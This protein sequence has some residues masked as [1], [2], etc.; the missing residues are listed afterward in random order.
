MRET[1]QCLQ[2]YSPLLPQAGSP[3]LA[4]SYH[5]AMAAL[6]SVQGQ[7]RVTSEPQNVRQRQTK[8]LIV[9][10]WYPSVVCG[11]CDLWFS[12]G[13]P[14]CVDFEGCP[15]NL[16]GSEITQWWGLQVSGA[17]QGSLTLTS[18][19][20]VII[21]I[22]INNTTEHTWLIKAHLPSSQLWLRWLRFG[23]TR[24]CLCC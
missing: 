17:S 3:H 5:R 19:I 1:L 4:G 2:Y 20:D 24:V 12:A 21:K 9:A 16:P 11:N 14:L 7:T 8:S 10:R 6:S 23:W 13:S 15:E 22:F 18:V